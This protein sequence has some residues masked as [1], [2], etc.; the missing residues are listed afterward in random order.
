[1]GTH[2]REWKIKGSSYW[3]WESHKVLEMQS[4]HLT[5]HK[6]EVNN[7]HN[8]MWNQFNSETRLNMST[9]W[10]KIMETMRC[11]V[12]KM[13]NVCTKNSL[14]DPC[15][16]D[17]VV[18]NLLTMQVMTFAKNVENIDEYELKENV[19]WYKNIIIHGILEENI[20]TPTSSN[21]ATMACWERMFMQHIEFGNRMTLTWEEDLLYARWLMKEDKDHHGNSWIYLKAR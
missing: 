5:Q 13:R 3:K 18:S 15:N 1:M 12:N 4:T 11:D 14:V 6:N 16:G 8:L 7:V 21:Y 17:N 20:E 9:H 10:N 2:D 19:L